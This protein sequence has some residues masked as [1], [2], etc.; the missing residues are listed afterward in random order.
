[1]VPA[2]KVNVPVPVLAPLGVEPL[3]IRTVP[4][5]A[6]TVPPVR[7]TVPTA[8]AP[9]AAVSMAPILRLARVLPPVAPRMVTVGPVSPL[10]KLS[11]PVP[12]P[13]PTAR[14]A[15]L[16]ALLPPRLRM[17]VSC[18][19][20]TPPAT[21]IVVAAVMTLVVPSSTVALAYGVVMFGT[22][23]FATL[24]DRFARPD[25]SSVVR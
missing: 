5:S 7:S 17:P 20:P 4:S 21:L 13:R 1:M 18:V 16:N 8:P 15:V 6:S 19:S 2:L 9:F 3:P 22:R 12:L 11:V 14:S 23:K 24:A 25:M 10:R